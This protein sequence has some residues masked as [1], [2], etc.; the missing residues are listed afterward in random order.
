MTSSPT[1][2]QALEN[3]VLD[4]EIASDDVDIELGQVSKCAIRIALQL[5]IATEKLNAAMAE[6][7]HGS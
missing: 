1:A 2:I 5:D 4:L 6:R 3:Q 7:Q